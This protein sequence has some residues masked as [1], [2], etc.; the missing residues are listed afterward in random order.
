M[1]TAR[2]GDEQKGEDP[3]TNELCPRVVDLTGKEAGVLLPTGTICNKIALSVHCTL[4][5]EV[6][7]DRS[8]HI[9][10][11]E[12]DGTAA[13]GGV[14]IHAV[15]SDFGL[16]TADQIC[17]AIP[18]PLRY[19]PDGR[20]VAVEQT[21]GPGGGGVW[22]LDQLIAVATVAKERDLS[23]HMDGTRLFNASVKMGVPVR[24]YCDLYDPVWVDLTK[25]LGSFA[26]PIFAGSHAFIN[27]A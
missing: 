13:L 2:V 3:T 10:N 26:R 24:D 9:G 15:D 20:L 12:A 1:L 6:I 4:G 23:T 21:K 7:C 16:F 22:P 11:F 14:V 8:C 18:T 17:D 25:G 5:E 19:A 27:D